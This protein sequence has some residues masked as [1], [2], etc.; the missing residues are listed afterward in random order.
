MPQSGAGKTIMT[1]QPRFVPDEAIE[2]P[3]SGKAAAR[4]RLADCAEG[5]QPGMGEILLRMADAADR[6]CYSREGDLLLP[7]EESKAI[8]SFFRENP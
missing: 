3:L 6:A 5:Q 4:I 2:L 8:R 7:C 1:T